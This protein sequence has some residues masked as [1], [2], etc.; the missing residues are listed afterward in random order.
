M[1]F[2]YIYTHGYTY[3]RAA[4]VTVHQR[5]DTDSMLIPRQGARHVLH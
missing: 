5:P 4:P 1:L 3:V 2:I